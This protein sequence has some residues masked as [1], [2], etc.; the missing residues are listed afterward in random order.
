ML[1]ALFEAFARKPRSSSFSM[2][3]LSGRGIEIGAH[4]LPIRGIQPIYVDRFRTFAGSACNADVL[5]DGAS[6]PF[7]PRSLDY[8]AH[9]HLL[10]HLPNPLLA[11]DEWYR[12]LKPGGL[13]YMVV[14]DRRFTFD[15]LRER[16]TMAHL[17]HDFRV[18]TT[19]V[20]RTHIDEFFEQVDF[21]RLHPELRPEEH[22]ERR[23][24][25]RA[26]H[27]ADVTG[28]RPINIHFHVFEKED[29]LALIQMACDHEGLRHEWETVAVEERYPP[30]RGDG[31]L[32]V[33]R[34][35]G[36]RRRRLF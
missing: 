34:R 24:S 27:H 22:R 35:K 36:A 6:L 30:D 32:V 28:G 16:T 20:D 18:G 1:H 8:I 23:E 26:N 2:A 31:F 19:A 12:A 11:L 4:G 21:G 10:E 14:P 15:H 3:M 25:E 7:P 13:L 5:A 29:V 17:G 9:S 33:V